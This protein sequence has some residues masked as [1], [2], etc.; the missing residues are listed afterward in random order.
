MKLEGA[1][2]SGPDIAISLLAIL[3]DRLA[4][5]DLEYDEAP[6]TLADGV[7]ARA[8]AFRLALA[9]G[10]TNGGRLVCRVF[11]NNFG[12][13]DQ[14]FVET[15]LH[16]AL[17]D[18]GFNA[19]RVLASGDETSALE[20]PFI[21]MERVEGQNAFTPLLIGLGLGILAL[22][23]GN[24]LPLVL[25]LLVYWLI[26]T[27][28]LLR[29]HAVPGDNIIEAFERSSVGHER[30]SIE[31]LLQ[32]F[33]RLAEAD[34]FAPLRP[35]VIWLTENRPAPAESPVVCHGDF[36]FGNVMVSFRNRSVA[37]LDW[38]EACIGCPEVD[39]GWMAN[40]HFS[41]LPRENPRSETLYALLSELIRP[42][43]WLLLGANCIAY[44]LLR[45]VD[46]DRLRYFRVFAAMRALAAVTAERAAFEASGSSSPPAIVQAWG[47][48]RTISLIVRKVHALTG[49]QLAL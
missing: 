36:W 15:T 38:T 45:S 5:P 42:L 35:L 6:E 27:R 31:T 11:Q 23:F 8:Y 46:P 40:Q 22:L 32:D 2:L 41:R 28:T 26:M 20:A 9:S 25:F 4:L 16:N 18:N 43:N 29:L 44:R 1:R 39:L 48:P 14:T 13:G 24:W 47:S 19:P 33:E 21:V 49:L 37:L 12:T 7:T 34:E 30:L 10:S 3:R 17:A